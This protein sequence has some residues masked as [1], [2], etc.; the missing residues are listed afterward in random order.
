MTFLVWNIQK[1]GGTRI[2]R[3]VE[4]I[5]AYDPDVIALTGYRAAPG[6]ALCDAMNERGLPYVE[7][8]NR[9][10]TGMESRSSPALLSN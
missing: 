1:G 7:T 10:A 4:E 6:V 3:I 2:P 8:P 9:P 5:S